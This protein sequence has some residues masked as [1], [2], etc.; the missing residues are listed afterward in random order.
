[1][2]FLLALV[3]LLVLPSPWDL[4]GAAASGALGV[5]EIAYWQRRMRANKVQ[6]GVENLVGATGEV[7]ETCNPLGQIR[8]LGELWQARSSAALPPGTAVRVVAL[9]GL[10]VE[11]APADVIDDE[12][13]T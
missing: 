9:N 1:M 3:L 8:V 11:V 2:F 4:V 10:V 6:T 5:L 7:T 13:R 12:A